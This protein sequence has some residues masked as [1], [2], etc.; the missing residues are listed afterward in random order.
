MSNE[1]SRGKGAEE[2]V[3]VVAAEPNPFWKQNAEKLVGESISSVEDNAKQFIA[4]TGLLQGIYF[5]AITFSDIR[6]ESAYSI[7]IYVAPLLLWLF[8][9]IF[10]MLVLFKKKYSININSSRNSKE[11]FEKIMTEKYW[12]IRISGMFLILS[13]V[14][15]IIA[16]LHYMGLATYQTFVELM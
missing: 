14:A 1:D 10:A 9:L 6:K 11:T 15:L 16:V 13:F 2:E 12:F 4:I 5:H 8:S 7:L 3:P